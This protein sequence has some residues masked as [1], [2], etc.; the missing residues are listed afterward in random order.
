MARVGKTAD[1]KTPAMMALSTPPWTACAGTRICS[2]A[3]NIG[4]EKSH[5]SSRSAVIEIAEIPR[6]AW[7]ALTLVRSSFTVGCMTN[8]HLRFICAAISRH[9][10]MLKPVRRPFSSNT[11]GRTCRVATRSVGSSVCAFSELIGKPLNGIKR[12]SSAIRIHR[13]NAP[14]G[15]LG[16]GLRRD[17]KACIRSR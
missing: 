13:R 2:P 1:E 5:C 14:C 6:S 9:N 17:A 4:C 12:L 16:F 8:C 15:D 7:R 10:S 11:N 3:S